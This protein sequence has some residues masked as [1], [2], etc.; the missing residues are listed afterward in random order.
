MLLRANKSLTSQSRFGLRSYIM[1][2]EFR[3]IEPKCHSEL[4]PSQTG[5]KTIVQSIAVNDNIYN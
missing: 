1:P 5:R 2:R 3:G 4:L